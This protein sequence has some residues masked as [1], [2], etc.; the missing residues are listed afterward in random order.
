MCSV[1]IGHVLYHHQQLKDL[2]KTTI[3]NHLVKSA[4]Q[5]RTT[6]QSGYKHNIRD[7]STI[8]IE[9]CL[10]GQTGHKDTDIITETVAIM[11]SSLHNKH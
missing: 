11:T 9:I 3:F 1:L 2:C 6:S 4:K 10:S 8:N 7:I 5:I